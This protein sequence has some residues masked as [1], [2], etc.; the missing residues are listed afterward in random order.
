MAIDAKQVKQLREMTSAGMM[1]CKKALEATNGNIDDAV[2]WLRENG[3]AKAA[4][5]SDRVAAE[6]VAVAKQDDISAVIMEVNSETD[7]V[8]KNK[9]FMQL[10]DDLADAFLGQEAVS[11]EEAKGITL[12]SGETVAEALT[13]ATAKIGEKIDLR[14]LNIHTKKPGEVVSVYNH[15]N[16]RVSVMLVF[17]GTISEDDAYNVAM[18]VAA[19]NPAYMTRDE[20]PAD[21]I[22]QEKH[23]ISENTDLTGK[24]ENIKENILKGKLNKRLAEVNLLDQNFVLD[25]NFKVGDFIKAKGGILKEMIRYEVGEGIEK[26]ETDFASE[27]AAQ[28][29]GG[30]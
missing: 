17:D 12:K 24:P 25:E 18:H 9:E 4:K 29:K 1:D 26:V 2:I 27:V 6:G 20:I 28:V 7:F 22:E 8:A 11:A 10:I 16:N 23:V 19:M 15:A 3:L 30:N 14:R 21:F 13:N 5:K